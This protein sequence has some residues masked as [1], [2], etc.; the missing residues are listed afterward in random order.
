MKEKIRQWYMLFMLMR[1]ARHNRIRMRFEEKYPD[2]FAENG[3]SLECM[4][5]EQCYEEEGTLY[6]RKS[7]GKWTHTIS[8]RKIHDAMGLYGY[9][10]G[11]KGL[12]RNEYF[13]HIYTKTPIPYLWITRS[14]GC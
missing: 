13:G 7:Q 9:V 10:N 11:Y 12:E 8:S 4:F 14:F 2:V 5:F 3:E 6:R 1:I